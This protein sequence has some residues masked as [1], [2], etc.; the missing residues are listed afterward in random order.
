MIFFLGSRLSEKDLTITKATQNSVITTAIIKLI[1]P[2]WGL[3]V[4]KDQL[5]LFRN[6]ALFWET[7]PLKVGQ[8]KL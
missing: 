5:I 3:L 4:A 7:A 2:T 8:K 6:T 1:Y